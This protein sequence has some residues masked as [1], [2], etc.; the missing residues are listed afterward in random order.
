MMQIDKHTPPDPHPNQKLLQFDISLQ[1]FILPPPWEKKI[2][3]ISKK[4]KE[5]KKIKEIR[6]P[7]ELM[8]IKVQICRE[9]S[10]VLW[11]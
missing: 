9:R 5:K 4:T 6:V 2:R 3:E 7:R 10:Y 11:H 1:L 8:S